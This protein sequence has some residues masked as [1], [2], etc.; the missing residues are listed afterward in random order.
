MPDALVVRPLLVPWWPRSPTP[1]VPAAVRAS[2]PRPPPRP[3]GRGAHLHVRASCGEGV[4][5]DSLRRVAPRVARAIPPGLTVPVVRLD[6]HDSSLPPPGSSSTSRAGAGRWRSRAPG[7]RGRRAPGGRDRPALVHLGAAAAGAGLIVAAAVAGLGEFVAHAAHAADL[8]DEAERGAVRAL[9]SALF[10][11]L[12]TS[13]LV[14]ALGGA[15]VAALASTGVP[16]QTACG[17]RGGRAAPPSRPPRG[18]AVARGRGLVAAGCLLI[19]EPALAVRIAV[20]R[21]AGR[22]WCWRASQLPGADP[23]TRRRERSGHAAAARGRDGGDDRAHG[24]GGGAG[25]ARARRR[26]GAARVVRRGATARA[27]SAPAAG[28][29]GV[30]RHPQLVR[31]ART[32]RGGCSPISATGSRGSCATGSARSRSTST[33]ARSDPS[34]GRMRTDLAGEDSSRN[35]VAQQLSPEALRIADGLV[36]RVGVRGPTA[37]AARTS[38]TRCASSGRSRSTRSCA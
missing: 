33:T 31:G 19:L 24:A 1:G 8:S 29:G 3:R 9:W 17:R 34:S 25:A 32:S 38:V 26:A 21:R 14:V 10:S 16:T 27:R 22:C 4:L 28:P 5:F 12:M 13:A 23:R 2:G 18:G 36:G 6:P 20:V 30:R 37:S 7:G 11:D 35:K 15:V